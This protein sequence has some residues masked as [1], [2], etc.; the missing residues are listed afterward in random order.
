MQVSS[1][2]PWKK[3]T[4]LGLV[5]MFS[6][7]SIGIGIKLDPP[8]SPSFKLVDLGPWQA[9]LG[10]KMVSVVIGGFL[11]FIWH[12]LSFKNIDL[13]C[14][15]IKCLLLVMGIALRG[16]ILFFGAILVFHPSLTALKILGVQI[17]PSLLLVESLNYLVFLALGAWF[18]KRLNLVKRIENSCS[19]FNE[20]LWGEVK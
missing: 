16:G 17:T 11:G 1:N 20:Y 5:F 3:R 6:I 15:K 2:H 19:R 12:L 7:L 18:V 13:K 8:V 14:H 9:L 4:A 10:F